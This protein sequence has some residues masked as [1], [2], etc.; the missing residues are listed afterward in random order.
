MKF[1][2]PIISL[3]THYQRLILWVKNRYI[4]KQIDIYIKNGRKPWSIGY[5]LFKENLIKQAITSRLTVEKFSLATSLERGYGEFI[6]ERIV[7]YPWLIS[8]ISQATGKL[9]DAGSVLNFDYI[10]DHDFIKIKEITIA[11]LEPEYNC[12]W[13]HRISYQFCDL[14]D[15]PFTDNLFD[16]VVSISTIEHIGM[17]NSIYSSN[18]NFIENNRWDF[19]KAITELKRVVKLGSKVYISVPYGRYTDFGWYQQ[20]NTEMIDILIETFSPSKVVETYF[21][22]ENGGWNFSDKYYCAGVEGFNIHDTKYY[23]PK[24]TK[25]YDLDFAACSR[26][27]AALELWK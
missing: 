15:L 8:R 17:N 5:G 27:I 22:Y 23:N 19:L 3:R 18:P 24:S 1:D 10:V 25:D 2:L 4:Q 7:E 26:A 21:C 11:T 6:D 9:L 13:Q 16:E 20:F 14:R 12:F